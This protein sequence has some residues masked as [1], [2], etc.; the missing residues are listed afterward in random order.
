MLGAVSYYK[1]PASTSSPEASCAARVDCIAYE[2]KLA[3][4]I[5]IPGYAW[6]LHTS[7]CFL[8]LNNIC[9]EH[10]AL[11]THKPCSPGACRALRCCNS[12][13]PVSCCC[14]SLCRIECSPATAA[15]AAAKHLSFKPVLLHP[16]NSRTGHQ[17]H[18][19]RPG[20]LHGHPGLLGRLQWPRH[21]RHNGATTG[22]LLPSDDCNGCYSVR[23][24][25][26]DGWVGSMGEVGSQEAVRGQC[27]GS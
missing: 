5:H 12:C 11:P 9:A 27:G 19:H 20:P 13:C 10:L 4:F 14:K 7:V 2:G 23:S 18:W 1:R 25:T 22:K 24:W 3:I 21:H 15:A 26:V 8:Q 6:L 16:S 17:A